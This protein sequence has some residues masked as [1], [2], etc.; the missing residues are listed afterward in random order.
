MRTLPHFLSAPLT[1]CL[2]LVAAA[3]GCRLHD[4]GAFKPN[5]GD[6]C[7]TTIA[8]QVE[9]PEVDQCSAVVDDG[10]AA[11]EPLTLAST[12]EL[13]YWDMSLQEVVQIALAQSP[14]IRDLGGAV[15]RI[16]AS[17]RNPLGIRRS[18]TP[19]RGSAST[20]R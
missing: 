15:L 18:S 2:L 8:T 7:Y 20:R 12:G 19:T 10:W 3:P 4:K 1:A 17:G 11:V 9:Y 5:C 13:Q 16:A 14:V 6:D